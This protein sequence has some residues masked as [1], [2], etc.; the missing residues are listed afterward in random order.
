M[1]C[2]ASTWQPAARHLVM[3]PIWASV[4][5]LCCAL[6]AWGD[7]RWFR[8]Y[9]VLTW[10]MLLVAIGLL[11]LV[12]VPGI[13]YRING[14]SRWLRIGGLTIQPSEFAKLAL[15]VVLA[16]YGDRFSRRMPTFWQGLVL[17]VL[18]VAPIVALVFL[19][20]DVGTALLLCAISS[21]ILLVAGIRWLHF[22]PPVMVL[23][24]GLGVFLWN[25]PMRS[26]RIYSWWNLEETKLGKGMQ[27]YQAKVALGSGGVTGVGLGDGRQKLGFVPEH[28]TDFIFSVVGEELGLIATL[29]VV[30]TFFAIVVCGVCISARAP[31]VFG[32]LLGSGITFLIGLQVVINIGVVTG[33]LPNKGLSLPFISYGGSN[34][35]VM[36]TA[37]GILLNIARHAHARVGLAV[38]SF[39]PAHAG[40][41]VP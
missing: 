26:E 11:A 18:L 30:L 32:M 3:Q 17:P 12:V 33:L 8:K 29:G 14:A 40:H 19:E 34:L 10:L 27:A 5:L 16:F 4:G 7:Y 38:G 22:V 39:E 15:I 2:S 28:H 36:L 41:R 25:N 21:V 20:P 37:V 23:A 9:S 1:L 35:V 13:G 31:D 24:L 6:A